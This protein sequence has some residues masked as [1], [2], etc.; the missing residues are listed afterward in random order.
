MGQIERSQ[1]TP[2]VVSII[3]IFFDAGEF[4]REAIDSV[5][6]QTYHNW[7]LLLVDDGSTDA[8]TKLARERAEQHSQ[9]VL[10]LEHPGRQNQGMSASRNLGIHHAAGD[11]LAFLD[12]DDVWLPHKLEE[13]VG[14]MA[15]QPEAAMVYGATQYWHSW[16][17]NSEDLDRDY[18]LKLGV[19]PNTLVRSPS[20][21][22]L[23]LESKAP[24]PCPSDILLR[25]EIVD[26][27]GGFE[28][29]FRGIYQLYEDQ[30][31]LA[32]V[33]LKAPVFV[34]GNCWDR[35]RQHENSCVAVVTEAGRKYKAGLFYL[36]WL[37]RYLRGNGIKE[38][39]VWQALR[40][41]R[42]R[43]RY[44]KFSPLLERLQHKIERL[45]NLVG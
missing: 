23:S 3:I 5:F 35:Y 9:K 41:K 32:K 45:K 39:E 2:P 38:R 30:A 33:Y 17:G 44:P 40:T 15:S 34:A 13:Q 43:Y 6:G 7:E 14:I 12:A 8:S 18:M 22:T 42:R 20:L 29:G 31:F 27:V 24:T 37:E 11:Y 21:L 19:E 36:D 25:R 4:I 28:E 16:T 1:E 10:Y 26:S